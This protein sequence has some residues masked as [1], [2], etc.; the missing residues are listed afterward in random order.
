MTVLSEIIGNHVS[1]TSSVSDP[2]DR[3]RRILGAGVAGEAALAEGLARGW[4]NCFTN[5]KRLQLMT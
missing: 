1:S 5:M 3:V 2:V 4:H